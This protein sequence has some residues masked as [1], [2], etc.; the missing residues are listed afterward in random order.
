MEFVNKEV[1]MGIKLEYWRP[2]AE[3]NDEQYIWNIVAYKDNSFIG[4]LKFNQMDISNG[5]VGIFTDM[6]KSGRDLVNSLIKDNP[7][8]LMD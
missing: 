1:Y 4:E 3:H 7:N 2:S 6:Q 8:L 5:F